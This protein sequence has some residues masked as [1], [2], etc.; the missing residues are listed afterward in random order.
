M[1]IIHLLSILMILGML[2]ACPS[3]RYEDARV[4]LF[5]NNMDLPDLDKVYHDGIHFKLSDLFTDSYNK[6]FV[7]KDDATT[8][9]IYDLDLN[10]SVES[11][12]STEAE[13]FKY[14][15]SENTDNLNAIHDQYVIKRQ[16]SLYEYFTSIKKSV[17]E[18]VGFN[19][20]IQTIEGVNYYEDEPLI[21]LM[22]TIEVYDRFLVF[23]LI[24]KKENMGYLYDDF[25][26]ILK[27]IEK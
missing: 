3:P 9:I 11:F 27:S 15:F 23:Q 1:K 24:G 17:P 4:K 26:N 20:V 12:D 22:A 13:M 25:L 18:K 2:T 19:G 10:F 5:K 7:I 21:Y 8:K 14:V 6:E 16:K